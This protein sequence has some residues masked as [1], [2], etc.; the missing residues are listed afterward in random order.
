MDKVR[1]AD[2][3]D[4]EPFI[5]DIEIEPQPVT[6]HGIKVNYVPPHLRDPHKSSAPVDIKPKPCP[7]VKSAARFSINLPDQ[8]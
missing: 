1:W 4:D 2:I 7:S 6:R 8:K 5:F 3:T